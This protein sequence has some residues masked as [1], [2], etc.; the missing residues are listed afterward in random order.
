MTL[1]LDFPYN[2]L[3]FY[4]ISVISSAY[5]RACRALYFKWKLF[6]KTKKENEEKEDEDF[7][8]LYYLSYIIKCGIYGF[9]NHCALQICNWFP[10]KLLSFEERSSFLH[11]IDLKNRIETRFFQ[12]NQVQ[13]SYLFFKPNYV[14]G[15][16][17]AYL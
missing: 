5:Q 6:C 10:N 2:F 9:P 8:L 4:P 1:I 16:S 7:Q 3:V 14:G 17:V 13:K 15:D 11:L 12:V